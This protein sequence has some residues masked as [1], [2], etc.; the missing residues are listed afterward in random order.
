MVEEYEK[1][2]ESWFSKWS[3][4]TNRL[5]IVSIAKQAF[6][7]GFVAAQQGLHTDAAIVPPA[8]HIQNSD[9]VPAVESDSQPRR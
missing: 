1:Q 3:M 5:D 4:Q 9:I 2:F 8:E 7:A 6:L